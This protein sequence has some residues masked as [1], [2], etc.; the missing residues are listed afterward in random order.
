[1]KL[2]PG[3]IIAAGLAV[4]AQAQAHDEVIGAIIGGGAG[5]II[6]KAIGGRDGAVIGGAIGAAAG[7]SSARHDHEQRVVYRE[8]YEPAQPR[9][10][11]VQR[12]V[13]YIVVRDNERRYRDDRHDNHYRDDDRCDRDRREWRRPDYRAHRW[14]RHEWRERRD[15]Y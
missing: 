8:R 1:M 13:S 3:I 10:V 14:E 9:Y 2:I 4:T 12:P 15:Y 6:G 7:A 11:V 5:A